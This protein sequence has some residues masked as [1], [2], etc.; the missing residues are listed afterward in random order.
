VVGCFALIA[1]RVAAVTESTMERRQ[2]DTERAGL[3]YLNMIDKNSY[4]K[5]LCRSCKQTDWNHC[6]CR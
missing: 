3:S 6:C 1:V 2:S 4:V 5:F